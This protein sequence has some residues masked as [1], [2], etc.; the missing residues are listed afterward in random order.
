M[1]YEYIYSTYF[2]NIMVAVNFIAISCY[3]KIHGVQFYEL[4]LDP[5]KFK[6]GLE[7]TIRVVGPIWEFYRVNNEQCTLR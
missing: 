6:D 4:T 3:Y 1:P 5:E 7:K 2:N